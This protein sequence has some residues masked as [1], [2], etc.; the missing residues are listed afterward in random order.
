MSPRYEGK[1]KNPLFEVSTVPGDC[2]SIDISKFM[3]ATGERIGECLGVLW[4]DLNRET[5]EVNCSH[6]IQR[7]KGKGLVR[8]RVKT[9]AGD[10]ILVLP[11]WALSMIE[12]RWIPGT[13]LDSPIFP[14][15]GGFRDPHNVRKALR[16]AR[17]PIGRREATRVG[18]GPS[19]SSAR[20]WADSGSRR[21]QAR[22]EQ[23]RISLI[24]TGRVRLEAEQ[25]MSLA[26]A[27][28]LSK[29]D[30]ASLLELTELAGLRSLA[31]ELAW[32]TSH[33]F[34]K[35]TAT[36]LDD[37]GHSPRQV[38]DQLGHSRTHHDAGRLH[39]AEGAQSCGRRSPGRGVA[40]DP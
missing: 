15:S 14:S 20:S 2:H 27:Y 29:G 24:E 18:T 4:E 3:L 8:L 22:M 33:K 17:Q 31:D 1:P 13:L 25:A 32:V 5:G 21:C 38:A 35:T 36:I 11:K 6:Q 37:A 26:E 30:R 39:R 7:V 16:D 34:R 12:D 10:R 23:T 28:R 40:I 9:E 19:S